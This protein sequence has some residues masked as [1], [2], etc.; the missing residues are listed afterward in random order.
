MQITYFVQHYGS[1]HACGR[2]TFL[3]HMHHYTVL[4]SQYLLD[5]QCVYNISIIYRYRYIYLLMIEYP[6]Q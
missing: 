4:W 2:H 5:M 6:A 3:Q 1:F